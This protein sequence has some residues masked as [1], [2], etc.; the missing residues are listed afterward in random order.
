MIRRFL[1]K[2]GSG[3]EGGTCHCH[4]L[5]LS[6]TLTRPLLHKIGG[7]ISPQAT[8]KLARVSYSFQS[9]G[10]GPLSMVQISRDK[11]AQS[12]V[13]VGLQLDAT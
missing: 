7:R 2:L 13:N 3:E 4:A 8:L 10:E 9:E 11:R 6:L 12:R 1:A 5:R